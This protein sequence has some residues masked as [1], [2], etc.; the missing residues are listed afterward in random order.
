MKTGRSGI[1]MAASRRHIPAGMA[2]LLLPAAC[3]PAYQA[4]P[5]SRE[6]ARLS[7]SPV[8]QLERGHVVHQEKCAKCHPFEDPAR[9]DEA[10]LA[11]RIMPEMA[12]KSKIDA[13]DEKAVLAYLL[14]AR[15]MPPPAA[16][17]NTP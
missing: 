6:L 4:P 1:S 11:N 8:A 12:R 2:V 3:G 14:A 17:T 13:A 16:E 5:V 15:R 7:R 10:D 9:Y